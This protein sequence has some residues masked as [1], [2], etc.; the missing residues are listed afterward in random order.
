MNTSTRK[1]KLYFK[2]TMKTLRKF[3]AKIL[4]TKMAAKL[5]CFEWVWCDAPGAHSPQLTLFHLF[6]SL[7]TPVTS[8][9]RDPSSWL[10]WVPKCTHSTYTCLYWEQ[11]ML[12][13]INSLLITSILPYRTKAFIGINVRE[14][15][16]FQNREK[17]KPTKS[18][19]HHE[20]VAWKQHYSA[21]TYW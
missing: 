6:I 16:D 3:I 18:I 12:N 17:F 19:T 8:N 1:F 7:L 9:H 10:L 14:I 21:L 4:Q 13:K 15:R 2:N 11:G 20:L 5:L